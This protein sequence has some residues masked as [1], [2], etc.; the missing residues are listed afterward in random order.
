MSEFFDQDCSSDRM[1]LLEIQCFCSFHFLY[2]REEMCVTKT[3]VA[4]FGS[5]APRTPTVRGQRIL[6]V[7]MTEQPL[8]FPRSLIPSCF[9]CARCI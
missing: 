6:E 2:T 9:E 7:T 1:S 8:F 5:T 3:L 4:P